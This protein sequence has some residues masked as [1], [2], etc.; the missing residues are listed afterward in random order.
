MIQPERHI[1][2]KYRNLHYFLV[3]GIQESWKGERD[4]RYNPALAPVRS[5]DTGV[6]TRSNKQHGTS[7]RGSNQEEEKWN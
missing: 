7:N 1:H 4:Y 5:P 6:R 3:S 2:G